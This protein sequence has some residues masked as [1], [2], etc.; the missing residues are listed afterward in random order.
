MR[1]EKTICTCGIKARVSH[2]MERSSR[3]S[4][5]CTSSSRVYEWEDCDERDACK[6]VIAFKVA[7]KAGLCITDDMYYVTRERG[8][9]KTAISAN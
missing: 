2:K 4:F 8:E 3:E 5:L 6:S 7:V 1:G 9:D